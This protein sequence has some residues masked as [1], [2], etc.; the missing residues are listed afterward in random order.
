M[1]NSSSADSSGVGNQGDDPLDPFDGI[2]TLGYRVLGVQPN[3]PASE[4]G[5]VSFLDFLV[6]C[7]EKI[8]LGSGEDL[9]PG[10]EYDDVDLPALL[11]ENKGKELE[12]CTYGQES[13]CDWTIMLAYRYLLWHLLRA[14][15]NFIAGSGVQFQKPR[16]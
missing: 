2:D 12:F 1:G 5:L 8:L 14:M 16:S 7:N 6:G 3:S 4:A 15:R 10:M 9:E 13:W 11:E